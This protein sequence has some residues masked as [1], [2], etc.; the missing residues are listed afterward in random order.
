M[1]EK[2][3]LSAVTSDSGLKGRNQESLKKIPC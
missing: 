1:V 2:D 3:L